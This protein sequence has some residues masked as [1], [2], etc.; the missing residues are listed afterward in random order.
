LKDQIRDALIEVDEAKKSRD[1]YKDEWDK[2][3]GMY[4]ELIKDI[5]IGKFK[6]MSEV[7]TSVSQYPDGSSRWEISL[8]TWIYWLIL[9]IQ[10]LQ[11]VTKFW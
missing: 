10:L 9:N 5:N 8:T 2:I 3:N 6:R 1:M 7:T 11:Y 4:Q